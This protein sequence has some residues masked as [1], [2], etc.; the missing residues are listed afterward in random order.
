LKYDAP[1]FI[2]IQPNSPHNNSIAAIDEQSG[3]LVAV[4]NGFFS[5][6][7]NAGWK[8]TLH[9]ELQQVKF[10]KI[11][12]TAIQN[13]HTTTGNGVLAFSGSSLIAQGELSGKNIGGLTFNSKGQLFA[14]SSNDVNPVHI[15][16]DNGS[17]VSLPA[18]ALAN[19]AISGVTCQGNNFWGIADNTSIFIYTPSNNLYD[20]TD[21]KSNNFAIS[22]RSD[23]TSSSTTAY[24]LSADRNGEVWASTTK[25]AAIYTPQSS[26]F[27]S[28]LE[29]RRVYQKTRVDGYIAYLL[30]FE[31]VNV[32]EVD[33]GN[34]KWFGTRSAGA[35]LEI[36]DG[37]EQLQAFNTTNSPL[38]S[39]N[40]LDIKVNSRTGEVFM[41]T[42]K[43]LVSYKSDATAGAE[44]FSSVKIYPNPVR[45]NMSLATIEGLMEDA[46]VKITDA[47][48][49]LVFEGNA[50]G[51]T[52][53]WDLQNLNGQRAV[54]GVYFVF[55]VAADGSLTRVGKILVVR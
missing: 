25:G 35:F 6:F 28:P 38:P 36:P 24:T 37:T 20:A 55:M 19:S 16:E 15:R 39:D 45:P 11:N 29:A 21:D 2:A 22:L 47:A 27:T 3:R 42:D 13:L 14:F 52:L 17:W 41:L 10:A 34:R 54:T 9:N 50:N 4:G 44:N 32:I 43:G 1:Q 5:E 30:E 40:V 8:N 53:T 12:P 48:G 51:G 18:P 7:E 31:V 33:G 26:M 23:F 46:S 49:N